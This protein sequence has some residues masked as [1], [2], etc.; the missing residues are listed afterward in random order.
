MTQKGT[1]LAPPLLYVPPNSK[2]RREGH[3][4]RSRIDH[5]SRVGGNRRRVLRLRADWLVPASH[6]R[7]LGAMG[8]MRGPGLDR[9]ELLPIGFG[10]CRPEPILQPVQAG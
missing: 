10:V 8:S 1:A 3:E 5:R 9:R 7:L 2:P 6:E 4:T